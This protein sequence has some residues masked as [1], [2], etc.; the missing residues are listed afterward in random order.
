VSSENE[1]VPLLP[2]S[3]TCA[4]ILT[5]RTRLDELAGAYWI[6]LDR[7]DDDTALQLLA[8]IVGWERLRAEPAAAQQLVEYCGGLPLALRIAGAR[9]ASRPHWRIGELARRLKNE[10]QRLDELSHRGLELRSS[11]ALSYRT[12]PESAKRL[13]RLIALPRTRE[14]PSWAAAALLDCSLKEAAEILARL[15]DVQL[16]R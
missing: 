11:I 2:G 12:L 15:V 16:L 9:L 14:L 3:P 1:V 5:S 10:V 13:F 7:F 8:K 6:S 4:V